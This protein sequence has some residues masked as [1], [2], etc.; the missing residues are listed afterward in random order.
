MVRDDVKFHTLSMGVQVRRFHVLLLML[1]AVFCAAGAKAADPREVELKKL[2]GEFWN[3]WAI[4]DATGMAT[5]LTDDFVQFSQ[6]A[7]FVDKTTF[8]TFLKSGKYSKGKVENPTLDDVVDPRIRFY[9][10]VAIVTYSAPLAA[11]HGSI[12]AA[13]PRTRITEVWAKVEGEGWKMANF[14]VTRPR[15]APIAPAAK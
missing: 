15:T 2:R 7:T 12:D 5:M 8:L 14:Q 4:G 3:D 9:G 11:E 1:C 6:S 13:T 10:T